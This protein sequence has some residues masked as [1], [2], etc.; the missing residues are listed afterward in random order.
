M[1]HFVCRLWLVCLNKSFAFFL[2]MV[3][4]DLDK[5]FLY[6]KADRSDSF[7]NLTHMPNLLLLVF[8]TV[9]N[10]KNVMVEILEIMESFYMDLFSN[11]LSPQ[12]D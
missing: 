2:E 5:N 6:L 10:V 11:R 4:K 12:I 9:C 7:R 3:L 1:I 8:F